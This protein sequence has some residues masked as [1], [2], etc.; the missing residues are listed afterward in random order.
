MIALPV[1][2]LHVQ[3]PQPRIIKAMLGNLLQKAAVFRCSFQ[4]AAKDHFQR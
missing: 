4:V 2:A 3:E 1:P